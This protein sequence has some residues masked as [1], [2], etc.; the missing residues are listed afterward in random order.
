MLARMG[1]QVDCASHGEEAIAMCE[2]AQKAKAGFALFILDLTI[3]GG[4]GGRETLRRLRRAGFRTP[5]IASSGYASDPIMGDPEAFG[6]TAAIAKP[7][8]IFQLCQLVRTTVAASRSGSVERTDLASGDGV[9][10]V[11]EI[12]RS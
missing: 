7:Y 11:Q 10:P 6:F 12:L 9:E 2:L 1:Y 4:L 3:P 8:D 5:A